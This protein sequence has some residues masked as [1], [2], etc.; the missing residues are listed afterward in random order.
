MSDFTEARD[1]M[2]AAF[3]DVGLWI[4]AST[5]LPGCTEPKE[6]YVDFRRPDVNPLTGV[7][8]ADY[9]IHYRYADAPTLAENAEVIVAHPEGDALYRV[10]KQPFID[11]GRGSDGHYRSAFLTRV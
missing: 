4:P 3:V 7:Q 6:F 2:D 5:V 11:P 9:E 8:S 1:A 10:R